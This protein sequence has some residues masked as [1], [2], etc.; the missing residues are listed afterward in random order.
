MPPQEG[1]ALAPYN[2]VFGDWKVIGGL[3]VFASAL[4]G[5]DEEWPTFQEDEAACVAK[6]PDSAERRNSLMNGEHP[7]SDFPT[8][9]AY[10][11][12]PSKPD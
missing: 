6:A 9:P 7:R 1:P 4:P 5:F 11:G 3:S 12:W 8:L 2:N 10:P